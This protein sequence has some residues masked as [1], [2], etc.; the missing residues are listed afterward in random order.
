MKPVTE[1]EK[2]LFLRRVIK[3]LARLRTDA[4]NFG[5][6]MLAFILANA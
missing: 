2:Q 1:D 5:L 6:D 3:D 4:G